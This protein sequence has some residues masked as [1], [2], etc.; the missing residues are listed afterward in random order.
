MTYA[1]QQDLIDRFGATEL[2][3]LTDL[4]AGAVINATTVAR[5]LAD[6]DAKIDS[7]LGSRYL[8]PLATVPTVLV[9]LAADMARYALWDQRASDAVAQRNKD[10]LALLALFAKGQV[11]LPGAASLAPAVGAVT[12]TSA[13]RPRFFDDS[14]MDTFAM[15]PSGISGGF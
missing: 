10:A 1:T 15:P 11:T 7:F 2:A 14:T 5:A 3:Q 6:T 8:L 9:G 13:S 12:V 4:V